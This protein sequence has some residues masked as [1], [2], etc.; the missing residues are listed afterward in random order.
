MWDRPLFVWRLGR[1]ILDLRLAIGGFS[2]LATGRLA[3]AAGTG[4]LHR[5]GHDR[6]L[7]AVGW[8][9][10]RRSRGNRGRGNR[11]RGNRG[12][13]DRTAGLAGQPLGCASGSSLHAARLAG[14]RP[15]LIVLRRLQAEGHVGILLR[16]VNGL[17][18]PTRAPELAAGTGAATDPLHSPSS[19]TID[20]SRIIIAV[21]PLSSLTV[22]AHASPVALAAGRH[23]YP[24]SRMARDCAGPRQSYRFSQQGDVKRHPA[25]GRALPGVKSRLSGKGRSVCPT[26]KGRPHPLPFSGELSHHRRRHTPPNRY[27]LTG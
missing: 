12:R 6:G 8:G 14:Q 3:I 17:F 23:G 2:R 24:A 9:S 25:A 20:S 15:S 22:G 10:G 4:V 7:R 18:F 21:P 27:S 5:D 26:R 19:S 1:Q 13:V 11:S 16:L